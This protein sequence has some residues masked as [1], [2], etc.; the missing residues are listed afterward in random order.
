MMDSAEGPEPNTRNPDAV[1]KVKVFITANF[2]SQLIELMDSESS[3]ER[4]CLKF[5]LY[6][7]YKHLVPRRK[8]FRRCVNTIFSDFIY[9]KSS[10]NGVDKILDI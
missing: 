2:M 8:M 9:E 5:I 7:L 4:E 1:R 10:F 6:S 3:E